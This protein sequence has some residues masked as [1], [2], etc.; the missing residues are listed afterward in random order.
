[1]SFPRFG[2]IL[3]N[4]GVIWRPGPEIC[5]GGGFSPPLDTDVRFWVF[6]DVW[7]GLGFQKSHGC[8]KM[9]SAAEGGRKILAFFFVQN[10]DFS[11]KYLLNLV[12]FFG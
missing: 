6:Q 2:A 1:M 5:Y 8:K 9:T 10:Q 4:F 11:G 7:G 3:G 12:V